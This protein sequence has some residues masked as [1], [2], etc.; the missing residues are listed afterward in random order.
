MKAGVVYGMRNLSASA[1][2]EP[3]KNCSWSHESAASQI[4]TG[5]GPR[6]LLP[7]PSLTRADFLARSRSE[8]LLPP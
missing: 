7:K 1:P 3:L 8:F 4:G 5:M 6:L 2:I